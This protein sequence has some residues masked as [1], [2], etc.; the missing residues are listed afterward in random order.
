M[1]NNTVNNNPWKGLNFYVEGEVL[2]GR[3]SEIESLSQYIVNNTQTVLYGKSG[4]GKSSILNAGVF[5]VARQLGLLPVGIR[6]DHNS[7]VS[8]IKQIQAAILRSGADVHEIVPVIDEETETLWEYLHRNIFFDG[9]GKRMQLLLVL[10]QFE[11]IFT[12]QQDEKKKRAFFDEL[13]D[14]LNDV[15]PLYIVNADKK[16]EPVEGNDVQ[17]VTDN[18]DELDIEINMDDVKTESA[19]RYLQKVDY[20]IVFTLR[21]DFLSYLERYTAYIPVMKSN[22]YGLLPINEEQA[23]DIIMKPREGLVSK[24]VAKLII[25][26]V[27][28]KTDFHID[29]IAEIDVDAAVLSLYLS[30]LYI[31][32]GEDHASIT[33]DLVRQFSDD[34]I[35]DFYE[36]SVADIP[37]AVIEEIE[38]QLLTY[39]GRRNNVSKNDLIRE[40][41]SAEIIRTLVEERKLLR[42]FSYQ[43]DIRVEFMHDILC[44]VVNDRIEQ[45]EAARLQ[46]EENAKA[47]RERQELLQRQKEELER[48]ERENRLQRK[49]N[50][51][52]F[53][54]VFSL[55]LVGVVS[56]LSWFFF[57]RMEFKESYA[58]FTV[59]DGW[60]VGIGKKLN[61]S[62]KRQM[63]VYYQLVRRGWNSHPARVNVLNSQKKLSQNILHES[64]LVRLFETEGTDEK[65]KD[66][67]LLQRKTSY[68]V[69]TPDNEGNV[70]RQTAYDIDGNELYAI[71]FFRSS[72]M[73]ED[74][75]T[76]G[77]QQKQLWANY[78]DKE[79]KSMRIRDN[80]ADRMRIT[81][82][83]STGYYEGYQF[84][85]ETGTPQ[86]NFND[87][88]GYRYQ[89][90]KDGRITSKSP[91][92]AFGDIKKGSEINYGEFDEFGRWTKASKGSAQYSKD[93]ITYS[94]Q[95]RTDS[96]RFGVTGELIYH[97]ESMSD[98]RIC[99]YYYDKGNVIESSHYQTANGKQTL[100]YRKK[101][102]LQTDPSLKLTQEFMADSLKPYRLIREESQKGKSSVS[103]FCGLD[104][105]QINE[106]MAITTQEGRY[107]MVITDTIQEGGLV[108]V[109][110][111]YLDTE[112]HPSESCKADYDVAFYNANHEMI[113]HIQYKNG[114][115]LCTYLNEYENG[116]IVAQSVMDEDA[117]AIR[118]PQWDINH[119]CYY[120]MKLVYDFS[121]TLVAIKGVNE[122]G[123]ESLITYGEYEYGIMPMAS[124]PIESEIE[125]GNMYGLSVYKETI[126][127]ID[128][129]RQVDYIHI[130]DK[131]GSWYQAGIRNGDLLVS[132]GSIIKVARSNVEGNTYD[133]LT[134]KPINGNS[135]T[136]H[137]AVYFTEKEMERYNNSKNIGK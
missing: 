24:D 57:N 49:K 89:L 127:H 51:M 92:D 101:S 4:I 48:I 133:I 104:S 54:V 28:G 98:G 110:R 131:N 136:E 12:L 74:G 88:Y 108:K 32:K 69:Y 70:S 62:E 10:D 90:A 91:V 77:T 85:S 35:K 38:D 22:R 130:T 129:N 25:Q 27:T 23:A 120:K 9:N 6:L 137:Y 26:K 46:A 113:K 128:R 99:N 72:A 58:N 60:P 18:L 132:E 21:E 44:P 30:R 107:H 31:K 83:A 95:S 82:N 11:E 126:H 34:I 75:D 29:G 78:V 79:G 84:F 68:W 56:W 73:S 14:L 105:M 81:I 125:N 134:F 135:G 17:E 76:E 43:D 13:A 115:I 3:N 94:M 117:K 41:V 40:G 66:F 119:L 16:P 1:A 124:Q 87:A 45:R 100:F 93:L 67:A 42:Q 19:S 33:A 121:N 2:Y 7:T 96:L 123:E 71:Q 8:Y 55:L 36:E 80:G 112:G 59:K 37:P 5:P 122:F 111:R 102:L 63:P 47:E 97:S 109:T 65:A 20:H 118:Y 86:P 50:R 52:R 114:L 116:L 61:D 106:P 103:Y 15:T 53:T 64:P 39:D